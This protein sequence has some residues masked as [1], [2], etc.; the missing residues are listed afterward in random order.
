M[1]TT[2]LVFPGNGMAVVTQPLAGPYHVRRVGKMEG[3]QPTIAITREVEV[4]ADGRTILAVLSVTF[5]RA[6]I[7]SSTIINTIYWKLFGNAVDV[8][9]M[10]STGTLCFGTFIL[11]YLPPRSP[12]V[13][14]FGSR[15]YALLLKLAFNILEGALMVFS[16]LL[17]AFSWHKYLGCWLLCMHSAKGQTYDNSL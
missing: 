7:P 13:C 14:F 12:W 8:L 5:S 3:L 4:D 10:Q 17:P 11:F 9:A 1:G 16:S 15:W 2:K 6:G